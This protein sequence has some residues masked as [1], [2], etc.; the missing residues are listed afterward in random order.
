MAKFDHGGGCPCG[1]H[2]ECHK[3]CEHH[4]DSKKV[5]L[6]DPRV[7]FG[8]AFI[9]ARRHD[10]DIFVWKGNRYHTKTVDEIDSQADPVLK[11]Y[12]E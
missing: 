10:A 8:R 9:E 2:R 4:P 3:G 6:I 1:L 12:Y 7:T 5:V 11:V